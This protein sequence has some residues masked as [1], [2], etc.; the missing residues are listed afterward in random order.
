M[1]VR[2]SLRCA[3]T[4]RLPVYRARLLQA[5]PRRYSTSTSSTTASSSSPASMLGAFTNELDR[6]A[7]KFEVQG[8][9]IQL[10]RTPAEFYETLK[11][12]NYFD[13]WRTWCWWEQSKI[14]GAEKRIFL[15]T[16]YIGKTEHELVIELFPSTS[17]CWLCLDC[18]VA[19]SSESQAT[20]KAQYLDRCS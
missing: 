8:S 16:L 15:S 4:R 5:K 20:I 1:I 10:L 17:I 11:V 7:P 13:I 19:T 18:Y 14:L 6:I 12:G 3:A 2:N 9:Q